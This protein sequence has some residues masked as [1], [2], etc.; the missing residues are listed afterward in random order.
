MKL[1]SIIISSL[2]SVSHLSAEEKPVKPSTLTIGQLQSLLGI[3]SFQV[4]VPESYGGF[5]SLKVDFYQGA[6]RKSTFSGGGKVPGNRFLTLALEDSKT[7]FVVSEISENGT[8]PIEIP[9]LHREWLGIYSY[10]RGSNPN[11]TEKEKL[12]IYRKDFFEA[13]KMADGIS[14]STTDKRNKLVGYYEIYLIP[15]K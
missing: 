6:V 3:Q 5:Y 10:A 1:N 11:T 4:K 14:F 13:V 12:V 8:Y 7:K 9:L 15:T 2:L